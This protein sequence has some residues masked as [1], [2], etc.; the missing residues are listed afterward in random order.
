MWYT[1]RDNITGEVIEFTKEIDAQM[2][3]ERRISLHR[4]YHNCDA[5]LIENG[6]DII[7]CKKSELSE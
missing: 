1:V 3:A 6:K 4:E 2:E 5:V 7:I